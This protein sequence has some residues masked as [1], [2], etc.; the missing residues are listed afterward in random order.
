MPKKPKPT[1]IVEVLPLSPAEAENRLEQFHEALFNVVSRIASEH[2]EEVNP[3]G[4]SQ[5]D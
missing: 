1:T 2:T 4:E 3:R 5:T